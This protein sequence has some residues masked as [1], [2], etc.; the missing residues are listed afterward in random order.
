MFEPI[1]GQKTCFPGPETDGLAAA[2]GR[3][4]AE[5]D[6]EDCDEKYA[7]EKN[8]NRN[9][10]NANTQ[11]EPRAQCARAHGAIDSSGERKHKHDQARAENQL[12]ACRELG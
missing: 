5:P 3:Q 9:P 4:P 12:E 10:K 6:R 8:R 11:N 2:E 7:G 1:R